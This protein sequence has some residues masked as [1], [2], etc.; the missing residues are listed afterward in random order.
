MK[1]ILIVLSFCVISSANA[2]E[3]SK[4]FPES[5]RLELYDVLQENAF[6]IETDV[7][8]DDL[9]ICK[10]R[11]AEDVISH[12]DQLVYEFS[13]VDYLSEASDKELSDYIGDMNYIQCDVKN[14]RTCF[15]ANDDS[16]RFCLFMKFY[17]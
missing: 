13:R 14:E 15:I 8:V 9:R 10:R 17:N 7:W 2:I 16:V 5:L 1:V 3:G 11:K 4:D 12:F 6:S